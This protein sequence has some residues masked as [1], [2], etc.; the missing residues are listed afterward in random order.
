M[1]LIF[2]FI[3][4]IIN[5][6]EIKL[7]WVKHIQG[8]SSCGGYRITVDSDGF[9]YSSGWFSGTIDFDPNTT[10]DNLTASAKNSYYI[11]KSKQN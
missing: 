8:D 10:T 7:D 4:T 5:A 11:T 9:I 2:L 6:Q 3:S 1:T